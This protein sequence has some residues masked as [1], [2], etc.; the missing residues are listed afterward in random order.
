MC[1]DGFEG[2]RMIEISMYMIAV[3]TYS[4]FFL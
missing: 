2:K 3:M 4:L 1:A